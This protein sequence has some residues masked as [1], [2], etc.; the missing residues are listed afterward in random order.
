[1]MHGQRN[2]K[3][4]YKIILKSAQ[5]DPSPSL[6]TDG[7]KDRQTGVMKQRVGFHNFVSPPKER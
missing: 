4:K 1:M 5:R 3:F 7:R 2:I 6:R